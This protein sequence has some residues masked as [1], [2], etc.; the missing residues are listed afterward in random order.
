MPGGRR[1]AGSTLAERLGES[2]PL[3]VEI[4]HAL[5]LRPDLAP[6]GEWPALQRMTLRCPPL[7]AAAVRG[8]LTAAYGR[9]PDEVFDSFSPAPTRSEALVQVHD[10]VVDGEPV[11]VKL[12][13]PGAR[14]QV[15][16]VDGW[17]KGLR[18]ALGGGRSGAEGA[19]SISGELEQWLGR[20]VDLAG[21][22]RALEHLASLDATPWEVLPATLPA[23]CEPG[24]LVIEKIAG[25]GLPEL[26]L[27][28]QGAS[29]TPAAVAGDTEQI[30][31]SVVA[32][33]LGQVLRRGWLQADFVA[34]N[35]VGLPGG[36]ITFLDYAH[37][38]EVPAST[39][40]AQLGYLA[41]VFDGEVTHMFPPLDRDVSTAPGDVADFRRALLRT[42]GRDAPGRVA[43]ERPDSPAGEGA[44]RPERF[45]VDLLTMSRHSRVPLAAGSAPIYGALVAALAA[46][47]AVSGTAVAESTGRAF[48]RTARL[49][50]MND[51]FR[52]ERLEEAG[53]SLV[54]FFRDT[55]GQLHQLL[56][57]LADGT[58]SL[59]VT[60]GE[61]PGSE[62]ARDARVRLVVAA[63]CSIGLAVLLAIPHLPR[64]AGIS[65]AWPLGVLLGLD[66][67][68][69][70]ARWR[71][72]R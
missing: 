12:L 58:F 11:Q 67:V 17:R 38:L 2:G 45:L 71:R 47:R 70:A 55:P 25:V 35:V 1:S 13:R 15:A 23:L 14:E 33:I 65:L 5:S 57:D 49:Q 6:D 59:N 32:A 21:E 43:L 16:D 61:S 34:A 20:R 24:V 31:A 30:A 8:L 44:S 54:S 66:Y 41:A 39:A 64:P 68:W 53:A 18:R 50:A 40:R 26:G 37:L 60:S 51:T 4:G 22:Q 56:S 48:L 52:P 3:Y 28:S 9:P 36:R 42:V 62:R 19:E 7:P 69:I 27:A 72:L 29:A 63:V 10:A 46:S